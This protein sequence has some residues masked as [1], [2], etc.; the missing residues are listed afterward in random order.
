MSSITYPKSTKTVCLLSRIFENLLTRID[1]AHRSYNLD[2]LIHGDVPVYENLLK[3]GEEYKM[4][5]Q[6]RKG[7][8]ANLDQEGCTFHPIVNP[9]SHELAHSSTRVEERLY[10]DHEH[11]KACGRG[12]DKNSKPNV[13]Q[14]SEKLK[15]YKDSLRNG[16]THKQKQQRHSKNSTVVFKSP[17]KGRKTS[18]KRKSELDFA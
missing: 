18:T 17:R 5:H 8:E 13:V 2:Q 15:M 7:L 9:K 6:I 4:K 16:T 14:L 12:C 3:K 11:S 1:I 10:S